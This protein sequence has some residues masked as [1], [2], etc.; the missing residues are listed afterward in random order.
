[1]SLCCCNP[2]NPS[3]LRYWRDIQFAGQKLGVTLRPFQARTAEGVEHAL[4][5][6]GRERTAAVIVVTDPLFLL[7]E[8]R[9]S[10]P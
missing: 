8:A 5:G 1:M 6:I 2:G 4:A 7:S 9:L 3:N 10:T